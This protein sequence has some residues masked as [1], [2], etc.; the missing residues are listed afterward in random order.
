[1]QGDRE[2]CMEVGM[3]DYV[4]K[5]VHPQA[6]SNALKKSL[7][8]GSEC[9][10]RIFDSVGLLAR[11]M[12]DEELARTVAELFLEDIP[13]QIAALKGDLEAAN[14]EG[15]ASQAH[16][17][18]GACAN[19]GG[20]ALRVVAFG[21]EQAAKA[22]DLASCT[23]RLAELDAQFDQLRGALEKYLAVHMNFEPE[24]IPCV[25]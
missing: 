5:P 10:R 17:I 3:N 19:M 9:G 2:R 16:A 12:G 23:S 20:E 25:S 18:K 7:Q 21:L 8:K 1:L 4:S 11:L 24:T 6:L 13:K 14:A 15:V 22:G